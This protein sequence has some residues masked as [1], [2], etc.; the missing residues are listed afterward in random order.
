MSRPW[1]T[2][3]MP[4][5]ATSASAM[6]TRSQEGRHAPADGPSPHRQVDLLHQLRVHPGP[7]R[8]PCV[9]FGP[10]AESQAHAPNE[11]TWKQDLVTCAAL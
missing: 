9:G 2:P 1:W 3:T 8:H 5:G 7:V 6:P 10:G 4:C 11:I